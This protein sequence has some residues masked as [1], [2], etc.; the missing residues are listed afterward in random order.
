MKKKATM[1]KTKFGDAC[2]PTHV[3]RLEKLSKKNL[4]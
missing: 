3:E 4:E 2:D 1:P